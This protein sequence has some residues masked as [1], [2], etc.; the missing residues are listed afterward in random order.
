MSAGAA[1]AD[2][3]AKN[4]TT[5][6]IWRS[7]MERSCHDLCGK[8]T[9]LAWRDSSVRVRPGE[10]MIS[11]TSLGLVTAFLLLLATA[12]GAQDLP[13]D[14]QLPPVAAP[15]RHVDVGQ[16]PVLDTTPQ[17]DAAAATNTYLARVSGA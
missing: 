9:E 3:A 12:A 10:K 8:N 14:Q 4:R 15:T 6:A 5:K 16:L 11:R 7:V 1:A 13:V 2:P 17:F